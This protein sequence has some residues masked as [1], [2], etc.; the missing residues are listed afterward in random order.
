ML[1]KARAG[2]RNDLQANHIK[3]ASNGNLVT[4]HGTVPSYPDKLQVLEMARAENQGSQ[5]I[6]EVLVKLPEVCRREDAAILAAAREA[7]DTSRHFVPI[8]S[9]SP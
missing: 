3:I 2:L 1:F 9:G 8:P 6:D 5:L 7:I 4:V